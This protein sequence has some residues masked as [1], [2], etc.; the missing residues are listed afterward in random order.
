MIKIANDFQWKLGITAGYTGKSTL[1]KNKFGELGFVD[2][3]GKARAMMVQ[4]TLS[5]E[6]K[7]KLHKEC[8][9]Y[10]MYL[11]NLV[12]MTLNGKRATRNEH[13]HEAKPCYAKQIRI[14]GEVCKKFIGKMEK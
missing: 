7:S 2:I 12:V 6:I 4:S 3:A 10:A 9:N 13:F 8:F 11:S 14:W 5:K 1:H